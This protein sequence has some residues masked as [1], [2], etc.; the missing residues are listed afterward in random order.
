M[1]PYRVKVVLYPELR[2]SK[3]G[4]YLSRGFK[5]VSTYDAA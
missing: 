3:T 2:A 1:D 4:I 5:V